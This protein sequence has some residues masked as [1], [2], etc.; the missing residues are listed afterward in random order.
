MKIIK[1][2]VI[3]LLIANTV[4]NLMAL[5]FIDSSIRMYIITTMALGLIIGLAAA[6]YSIE[7]LSLL[8]RTSIHVIIS[9]AAFLG[10][11]YLGKWFPFHLWAILSGAAIFIGIFIVI[12]SIFYIRERQEIKR[13]ND[14]LACG[15]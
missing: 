11:A 5:F 1:S 13:I 8:V 7:K 6:V 10:A 3:G 4:Y 12:W 15:K 9:F 2:G 14:A